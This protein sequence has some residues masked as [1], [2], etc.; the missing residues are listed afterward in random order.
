MVSIG[1]KVVSS[2]GEKRS[3]SRCKLTVKNRSHDRDVERTS[4]VGPISVVEASE[5]RRKEKS[6]ISSYNREERQREIDLQFLSER[7]LFG[8]LGN[9]H[10]VLE[11]S[12]KLLERQVHLLGDLFDGIETL[13][14]T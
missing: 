12:L 14:E 7:I 2:F 8:I 13:H 3:R 1:T 9:L 5:V 11:S 6:V 10:V 4:V